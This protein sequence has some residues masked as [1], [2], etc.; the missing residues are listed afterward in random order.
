M[1]TIVFLGTGGGRFVMLTQKRATGGI[2]FNLGDTVIHA[3]PGPGAL[4]RCR[5]SQ[6]WASKVTHLITTH[7]HP[8]HCTDM[9]VMIEA[10]TSSA[11]KKRGVLLASESVLSGVE[12]IE[13]CISSFHA[14]NLAEKHLVKPGDEYELGSVK[15]RATKA[16]HKDP[17]TFGFVLEY[18]GKKIAYTSDTE[19][20][21][22]LAEEYKDID[23][24]IIGLLRSGNERI[25]WHLCSEDVVNIL[26][27]VRPK[28]CVL[29]HFGMKSLE[30]GPEHEASKI[31]DETGVRTIAAKDGQRVSLDEIAQSTLGSF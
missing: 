15:F 17:S 24:L 27:E 2:R 23:I 9:N 4:V 29:T 1:D 18:D 30:A 28:L 6:E 10:M 16:Q 3:D 11:T 12:D 31:Q 7:G 21:E 8:D 5:Q 19:Y 14:E 22:G 26:N 25:K 20:F 13:P